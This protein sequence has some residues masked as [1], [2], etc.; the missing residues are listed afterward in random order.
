MHKK[1]RNNNK[2]LS[3]GGGVMGYML[4]TESNNEKKDNLEIL[5]NAAL[6]IRQDIDISV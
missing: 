5:P 1:I 3:G 4:H 2:V 6:S